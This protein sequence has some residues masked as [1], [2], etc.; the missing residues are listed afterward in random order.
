[1]VIDDD[2]QSNLIVK[3]T[4][5]KYLHPLEIRIFTDPAEGLEWIKN[6]NIGELTESKTILLLDINMPLM[7]GWEFLEKFEKFDI[8]VQHQFIIFMLSSS[9]DDRDFE[10]AKSYKTVRGYF[11]KPLNKEELLE[12][13][14]K[15]KD[16]V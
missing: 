3:L 7:S 2:P 12:L 10:M 4:I 6:S 11:V 5:K 9:V 8:K 16:S 15:L 13:V 1:M 14:D